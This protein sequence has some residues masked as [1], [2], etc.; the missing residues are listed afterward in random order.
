MA[1][2]KI[3]NV[4]DWVVNWHRKRVEKEGVSLEEHLRR[5]WR[6]GASWW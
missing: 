1:D 6:N 2:V 3:R 4:P 5:F